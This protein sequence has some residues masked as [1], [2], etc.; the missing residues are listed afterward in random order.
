MRPDTLR[1]LNLLQLLSEIAIAVGYLLGLIPF[2]YLWSYTWV[3]P[4]VF[5]NLVFAILTHNG[6]TT[7]T[8]IN[9]IMAFLSFIP[10]AGYVF[11]V[12]GIVISWLNIA[13]LAKE[14]R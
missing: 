9:I 5:V 8:V 10:V 6:T 1:L 2:V 7:K 12:V 4:L 14:R 3:I 13:A 11:R